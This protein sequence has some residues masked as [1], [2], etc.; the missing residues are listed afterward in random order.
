MSRLCWPGCSLGGRGLPLKLPV[1]RRLYLSCPRLGPCQARSLCLG[2]IW[3]LRQRFL[4]EELAKRLSPI[5]RYCF[6]VAALLWSFRWGRYGLLAS[7]VKG[8]WFTKA[9]PDSLPLR[10]CPTALRFNRDWAAQSN[11]VAILTPSK[12]LYFHRSRPTRGRKP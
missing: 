3:R 4:Q 12:G 1:R 11:P 7:A 9:L 10:E 2:R 8:S 5:Y 6:S